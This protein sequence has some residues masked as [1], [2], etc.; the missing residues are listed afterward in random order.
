MKKLSLSMLL[1]SIFMITACG[2]DD[3]QTA[4]NDETAVGTQAQID[5]VTAEYHAKM[6]EVPAAPVEP[7]PAVVPIAESTS[8]ASVD[9]LIS[10][11]GYQVGTQADIDQLTAEY[12]EKMKAAN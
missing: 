9:E 2:N 7:E 3:A 11:A 1:A 5:S 10:A 6:K 12:H 4:A 8:G